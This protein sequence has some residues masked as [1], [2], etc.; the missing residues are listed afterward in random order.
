MNK[1]CNTRISGVRQP[2]LTQ[3]VINLRTYQEFP[4]LNTLKYTEDNYPLTF[5]QKL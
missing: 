1:A 3:T 2:Q 4:S 5:I